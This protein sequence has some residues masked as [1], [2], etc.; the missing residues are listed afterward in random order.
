M[1]HRRYYRTG[2]W[3][4]IATGAIHDALDLVMRVSPSPAD[5][6]LNAAMRDLPFDFGGLSRSYYDVEMGI[7]LGMGAAMVFAGGLLLFIGQIA[8]DVRQARQAAAFGLVGSVA[9]FAISAAFEPLPPVVSFGLAT[10][11]FAAAL[12]QGTTRDTRSPLQV[13][14]RLSTS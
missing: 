11:A 6:T 1:K 7:S 2:A 10:L 8:A 12:R 4:W 5:E 9:L 14:D 13:P 3:L